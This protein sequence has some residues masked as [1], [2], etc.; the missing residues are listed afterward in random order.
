MKALADF[1]KRDGIQV[2]AVNPGSVKT[3]RFRSRLGRS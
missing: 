3:D 2:N 1:G